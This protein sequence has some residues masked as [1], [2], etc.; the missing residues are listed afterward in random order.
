[1]GI[2]CR[3][4]TASLGLVTIHASYTQTMG[5]AFPGSFSFDFTLNLKNHF[6]IAA[7]VA[8]EAIQES[9]KI[10]DVS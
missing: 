9:F 6:I 7:P 10:V 3:I 1:M 2:A 5:F 8:L 4:P